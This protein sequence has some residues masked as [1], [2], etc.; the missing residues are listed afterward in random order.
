MRPTW[1]NIT[2]FREKDPQEGRV[3]QDHHQT[4]LAFV[5][6]KSDLLHIPFLLHAQMTPC[7]LCHED[8]VT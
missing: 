2:P 8:L 4:R 5:L 7:E 3:G 6:V 1:K